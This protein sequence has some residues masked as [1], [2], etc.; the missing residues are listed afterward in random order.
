MEIVQNIKLDFGR[1]TMPP[2]VFAKQHDSDTRKLIITPLL[3]GS[4]YTLPTGV[5]ARF[6][7]TKP[8]GTTIIDDA[9]ISDGKIVFTLTAQSLAADGIGVAEIG[10]YNSNELLTTQTFYIDISKGAYSEDAVESS[11]EYKSLVDLFDE[12]EEA[13]A[14]IGGKMALADSEYVYVPAD[15]TGHKPNMSSAQFTALPNGQLFYCII[16]HGVDSFWI[17]KSNS[18][19]IQSSNPTVY[20]PAI[21]SDSG[22][23]IVDLRQFFIYDGNIYLRTSSADAIGAQTRIALNL[24][25]TGLMSLANTLVPTNNAG[26]GPNTSS[27][28]Y[29]A[30]SDGQMFLCYLQNNLTPWIKYT[31]QN[32]AVPIRL[33]SYADVVNYVDTAIGGI[34]NGSY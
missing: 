7:M 6:H 20:V 23:S 8:D 18:S 13:I 32:R 15:S 29:T 30:L 22:L 31:I 34:E 2:S 25:L 12:A 17:K 19:C 28:E 3:N 5:T 14:S 21:S 26:T 9:Q 1:N 24:D 4:A 16:D 33:S 27:S 10:L 11:D